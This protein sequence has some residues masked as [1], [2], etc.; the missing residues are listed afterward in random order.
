MKPRLSQASPLGDAGELS[1]A[2]GKTS[3]SYVMIK[4]H[5]SPIPLSATA[6]ES[7]ITTAAPFALGASRV[8]HAGHICI[9]RLKLLLYDYLWLEQTLPLK[10]DLQDD[11]SCSHDHCS[12]HDHGFNA[13][14]DPAFALLPFYLL[15][16][17]LLFRDHDLLLWLTTLL[18][19]HREVTSLW[20]PTVD[21]LRTLWEFA[22]G[23]GDTPFLFN[24][25]HTFSLLFSSRCD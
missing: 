23:Q 21:G 3:T 1:I 9:K 15:T 24:L 19:K 10:N 17:G 4:Q 7:L 16:I 20:G 12:S 13:S 6:L 22:L 2:M 14:S 8:P 5:D 18:P 11:I 25:V